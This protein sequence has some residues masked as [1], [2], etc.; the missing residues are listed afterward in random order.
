MSSMTRPTCRECDRYVAYQEK[1]P[2]KQRGVTMCRGERYCIAFSRARR[3]RSGDPK[4]Y[5]PKWCPRR[6][7]PYIL[8]V[9][10]ET[11]G[12]GLPL[13]NKKL[14]GSRISY[15]HRYRLKHEG[16]C[17]MT[18]SQI[19]GILRIRKQEQRFVGASDLQELLEAPVFVSNILE[20]DDGL[21]PMFYLVTQ[22]GIRQ[23]VFDKEQAQ[24]MAASRDET[25]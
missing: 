1:E 17:R 15:P 14:I 3:F 2:K 24:P 11:Q 23:V 12:P 16:A 25:E 9:Y 4:K 7:F 13:Q 19:K 5:V 20:L 6:I 10:E 21:K 22:S 18:G 8:R